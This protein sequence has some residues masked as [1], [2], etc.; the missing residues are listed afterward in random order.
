MKKE[1]K[2]GDKVYWLS[3][4]GRH[5]NRVVDSVGFNNVWFTNGGWMSID[6]VHH[7]ENLEDTNIKNP[8]ANITT[9]I[10]TLDEVS[11]A[12]LDYL[13]KN[14]ELGREYTI[15]IKRDKKNGVIYIP[16]GNYDKLFLSINCN[17]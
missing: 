10:Y 15:N 16:H 4:H 2:K 8:F 9:P 17:L 12:C 3:S 6:E 1:F 5:Y 14:I 13:S 7:I 11:D